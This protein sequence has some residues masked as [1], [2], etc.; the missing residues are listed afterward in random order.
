MRSVGFGPC[1]A[2]GKMWLH[3]DA[4]HLPD[5]MKKNQN[6]LRPGTHHDASLINYLALMHAIT[7]PEAATAGA[8]R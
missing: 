2:I 6:P 5:I 7:H 8:R 1:R 3:S 4:A